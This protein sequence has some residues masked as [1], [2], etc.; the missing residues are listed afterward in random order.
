MVKWPRR[1]LEQRTVVGESDLARRFFAGR[2]AE[3]IAATYDSGGEIDP[4]DVGFVVGALTF[5]NRTD[6]AQVAF[7]VWRARAGADPDP[8][9]LAACRFFLGLLAARAGNFDRSFALLVVEG[10]RAR[11]SPD[12]WTRALVF[13]GIACHCYFTGRYSGAAAN[14]LRALL[15]A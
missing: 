4:A 9:T 15:A 1:Q 14:A 13:Q 12:P 7:E 8:R 3:V 10:G 11:H 2:Y 6:D 5:V